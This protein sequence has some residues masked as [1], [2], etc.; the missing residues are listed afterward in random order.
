MGVVACLAIGSYAFVRDRSR[1]SDGTLT[2]LIQ[3]SFR[4]TTPGHATNSGYLSSVSTYNF[5]T[6]RNVF[7][8]RCV[9]EFVRTLS[10]TLCA[11]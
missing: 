5:G 2:N 11:R 4:Y 3:F 8:G 7:R 1:F 6:R 9:N 10:L